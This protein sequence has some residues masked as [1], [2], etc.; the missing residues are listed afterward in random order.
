[1]RVPSGLRSSGRRRSRRPPIPPRTEQYPSTS[2]RMPSLLPGDMSTKARPLARR[3]PSITSKAR[4]WD[5]PSGWC[6]R[7]VSTM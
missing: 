4:M 6:E 5:G 1:M 7:P 2:Q 3:R